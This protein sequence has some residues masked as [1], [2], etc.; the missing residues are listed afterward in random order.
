MK[1]PTLLFR[2]FYTSFSIVLSTILLVLLVI[3]PADAIRQ[4][5]T[6]KQLYNVFVLSSAYF[7]T[8]VVTLL[9]YASRLYYTR[10]VLAAI[11]KTYIP[12]EDG[13]VTAPVRAMIGDGLKRSALVAWNARPRVP[14]DLNAAVD[15][16]LACPLPSAAA[17]PRSRSL[18]RHY[19]ALLH[20]QR[21]RRP[22][23][24]AQADAALIP[25]ETPVWGAVQHPGWSSPTSPDLPNLQYTPVILEL[26]HLVEAR[27]V[28]LSG[29]AP[30]SLALLPRPAHLGLR[31][32]VTRLLE[33]GVL[34]PEA[35]WRAFL[36]GYEYARFSGFPLDEAQFR[37]LMR[38]FADVLRDMRALPA[39][40][41]SGGG[42]G[43][44]SDVGS[45]DNEAGTPT[46]LPRLL[47]K[48]RSLASSLSSFGGA[49][50]ASQDTVER[51]GEQLLPE[52]AAG[53]ATPGFHTPRTGT[54]RRKVG[55]PAAGSTR[56]ASSASSQRPYTPGSVSGR[57]LASMGSV[58]HH[59]D[60]RGGSDGGVLDGP[61]G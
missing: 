55:D 22:S 25:S 15:V 12:I 61:A 26:P 54:S 5:L 21:S 41:E 28:S 7:I 38:G 19:H 14:G 35:P 50:R 44:A 58:I 37:E 17:E 29:P 36:E 48:Q 39:G 8:A 11:P 16:G 47:R 9:I 31:E 6:N 10:S 52:D 13:D 49:S 56:S 51:R 42:S 60:V 1:S 32:Y 45:D 20:K 43:Y 53:Y 24:A 27:A 40:G 57:S 2:V 33:L 46:P 59:R 30:A 3:T 4:A 23:P 34:A 18:A